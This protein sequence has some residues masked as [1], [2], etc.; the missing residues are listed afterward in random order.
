MVGIH[1]CWYGI[2]TSWP[3]N[4]TEEQKIHLEYLTSS[5]DQVLEE[6]RVLK[7]LDLEHLQAEDLFPA[8]IKKYK[9]DF[10]WYSP[11]SPYTIASAFVKL[12]GDLKS[13]PERSVESISSLRL[14]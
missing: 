10:W 14:A 4:K 11:H 8:A 3:L 2:Q 12:M 5:L 1:D 9:Q 6:D 13:C 7:Y